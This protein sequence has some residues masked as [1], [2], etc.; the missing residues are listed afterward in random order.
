MGKTEL[1][2]RKKEKMGKGE[3]WKINGGKKGKKG[4]NWENGEKWKK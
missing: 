4:G 1:N 2:E 3:K